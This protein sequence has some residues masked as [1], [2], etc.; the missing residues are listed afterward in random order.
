MRRGG[1][2]KEAWKNGR[3]R[4]KHW[5]TLLR[6]KSQRHFDGRSARAGRYVFFATR[7]NRT[8]IYLPRGQFAS[9]KKRWMAAGTQHIEIDIVDRVAQVTLGWPTKRAGEEGAA[10]ENNAGA[11][12]LS[13]TTGMHVES[14]R[15][16]RWKLVISGW[17][18][19]TWRFDGQKHTYLWRGA[20]HFR[21]LRIYDKDPLKLKRELRVPTR[22]KAGMIIDELED[23]V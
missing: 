11:F 18:L 17:R 12:E 13:N 2:A 9:R 23:A 1:G 15:K 10:T 8:H 20:T 16:S 6:Q 19:A 4:T 21:G 5:V 14:G 7:G 3:S 22:W